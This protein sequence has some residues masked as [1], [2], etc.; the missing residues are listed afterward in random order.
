MNAAARLVHQRALTRHLV[1][2]H[3]FSRRQLILLI[4]VFAV[5]LSALGLIYVTHTTRVL[6]ANYQRNLAEQT[7]LQI[8]QG[9]LLLERSTWLVQARIQQIAEQ[10]LGM[11]I[12]DHQSV[13]IIRE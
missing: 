7:Q 9:Q 2:T 12:P 13:V 10:Q 3:L 1:F 6:H 5:L 8:Q 4:L 11:V